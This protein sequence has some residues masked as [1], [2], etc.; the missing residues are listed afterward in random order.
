MNFAGKESSQS[1]KT[2]C[3]INKLIMTSIFCQLCGLSQLMF[4]VN[5]KFCCRGF[6]K[7]I[8]EE[9]S[10][11]RTLF[12]CHHMDIWHQSAKFHSFSIKT[13]NLVDDPEQFCETVLKVSST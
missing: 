3:L 7:I 4:I 8:E 9:N 11:K 10:R 12:V 5:L 1:E 6:Q 13:C 2:L